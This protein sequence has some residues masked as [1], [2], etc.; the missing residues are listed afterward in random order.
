[1]TFCASASTG[2]GISVICHWYHDAG[3]NSIT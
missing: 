3:A 2:A 1:M